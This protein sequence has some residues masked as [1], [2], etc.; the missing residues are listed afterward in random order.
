MRH[1]KYVLVSLLVVPLA[2]SSACNF[3]PVRSSNPN[4][5]DPNRSIILFEGNNA[6]QDRI[7]VLSAPG[8]RT[9]SFYYNFTTSNICPNDEARSL[10]LKGVD[11]GLKVQLFDDSSCTRSDSTTEIRVK[12]YIG[13]KEIGTFES[14]VSDDDV[15]VVLLEGGNLD[16]KV[17]CVIVGYVP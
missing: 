13:I 17:S 3:N 10:V 7:C 1:S 8:D 15:D 5:D 2:L 14:A 16:G 11:A 9:N 4:K 12:R 6:T